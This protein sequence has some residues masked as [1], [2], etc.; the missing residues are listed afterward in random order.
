MYIN[1]RFSSL[2][3]F[4][5]TF[6]FKAR[7]LNEMKQVRLILRRTRFLLWNILPTFNRPVAVK[8][9]VKIILTV[10]HQ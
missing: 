4:L 10:F 6:T 2:I 1:F 3:N 8:L 5:Q 9:N 7:L